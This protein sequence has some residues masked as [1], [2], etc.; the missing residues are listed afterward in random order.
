MADFS[1]ASSRIVGLAAIEIDLIVMDLQNVF[2]GE[3][4]DGHAFSLR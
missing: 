1:N 2:E 3:E 4:N